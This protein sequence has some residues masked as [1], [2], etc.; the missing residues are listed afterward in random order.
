MVG[1]TCDK[2]GKEMESSRKDYY[3]FE[4]WV[5]EEKRIFYNENPLEQKTSCESG[6]FYK[7]SFTIKEFQ[8]KQFENRNIIKSP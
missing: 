2:S 5:S 1:H 4:D 8:E 3:I 6:S 7:I